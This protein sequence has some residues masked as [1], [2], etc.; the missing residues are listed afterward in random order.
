MTSVK[1]KRR[2]VHN[3][4]NELSQ[5]EPCENVC[6]GT[7]DASRTGTVSSRSAL[8]SPDTFGFVYLFQCPVSDAILT[9]SFGCTSAGEG[10][11]LLSA[12]AG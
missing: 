2:R 6:T 7:G 1:D 8:Q 11:G 9:L 12:T 10:S 3:V 4:P 5:S